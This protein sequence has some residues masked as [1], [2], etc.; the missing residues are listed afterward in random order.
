MS[1]LARTSPDLGPR[2]RVALSATTGPLVPLALY[3]LALLVGLAAVTPV[4]SSLHE[5][6]AYYVEVA[7]NVA[8]GRGLVI[9][10]LWSYATPPLVLPRPAFE[11]WQPL[12][13]LL[14]ALPMPLLGDSLVSA[15]MAFAALGAAVAPLAWA[16]ARDA[17]FRLGLSGRRRRAMALGSGLLA[18]VFG[19][20][21][22]ATAAP[23]STLPFLVLAG[24]ACLL[25]PA[26]LT[27]RR[28][29]LLLGVVLGLAYL[30]RM[31]AIYVGL[32]F[33]LLGAAGWRAA[34][35][36][37]R[38]AVRT[39]APIV[40]GG[41][42]VCLPWLVRNTLTFGSPFPGQTLDNAFL[43]RN[44]QIF[45]YTER[46]TLNA[47]LAQ[48]P[49]LLLGNIFGALLHGLV[50]VLLVPGGP[51]IALGLLSAVVLAAR[52]GLRS[53]LG[54]SPLAALLI[55]GVLTYGVTSLVFPVATV[56]GTFA[57]A[58]GPL[59]LGLLV[60]GALGADWLVARLR[61]RRG[62]QRSNAWLAPAALLAFALPLSALQLHLAAGQA[63]SQAM[64][65]TALRLSL[66]ELPAGPLI[67]DRPIWLA[68][69]LERPVLVLPDERAEAVLELA[70]DFGAG[71][72]V[73][74]EGR[75]RHPAALRGPAGSA[76]FAEEALGPS[77]PAGAALFRLRE[78]CRR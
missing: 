44:E 22:L 49:E 41:L 26:A 76:C 38:A 68:T 45:G 42:L 57:H 6:S 39:L 23:D 78:E 54:T 24:L 72:V 27:R 30:S 21:L 2:P 63:D 12:A 37:Y 70:R 48:G 52:S 40:A 56:W 71:A 74:V 58:S 55:A 8:S 34:E 5:G 9:D 16:V 62:W 73:I 19:P 67:S 4:G 46:P 32:T 29:G 51:L 60:S 69:A 10:V 25:M 1:S 31:E 43:T 47:F 35:Q 18:A 66:P 64:R 14:A 3:G 7:R 13:S 77:A 61:E 53:A 11:L 50:H 75:G 28:A 20:F 33:L 17:A 65:M 36:P 15:Q 59:L